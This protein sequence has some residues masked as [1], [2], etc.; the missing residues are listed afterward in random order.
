MQEQPG[1]EYYRLVSSARP[2]PPPPDGGRAPALRARELEPFAPGRAAVSVAELLRNVEAANGSALDA[3]PRVLFEVHGGGSV[4]QIA[5]ALRRMRA[6]PA[7][8]RRG[9]DAVLFASVREPTQFLLSNLHDSFRHSFYR[10]RFLEVAAP[11]AEYHHAGWHGK[12]AR[13]SDELVDAQS[14][15][16]LKYAGLPRLHVRHDAPLSRA[17]VESAEQ[18]L[19]ELSIVGI[20]HRGDE[21]IVQLI[22]RLGL[23]RVRFAIVGSNA[24]RVRRLQCAHP[25]WRPDEQRALGL[26]ANRSTADHRLYDAALRLASARIAALPGGR[27]HLDC[28]VAALARANA[29]NRRRGDASCVALLATR[30]GRPGVKLRPSQLRALPARGTWPLA[31]G[32]A[33]PLHPRHGASASGR[34]RALLAGARAPNTRWRARASASDGRI[35]IGRGAASWADAD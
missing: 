21:L 23:Q 16:L 30:G 14:K 10:A 7:F 31:P 13:L 20:T 3:H 33:A 34:R 17:A 26:A 15:T 9:C 11:D 28:Q 12:V 2:L 29:A 22:R 24:D 5:L 19:H 27:A 25:E 4:P 32:R 35:P 1:Y 6:A 18:L 8:A